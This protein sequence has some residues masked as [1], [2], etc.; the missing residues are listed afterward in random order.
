MSDEI[1]WK[2]CLRAWVAI[3]TAGLLFAAARIAVGQEIVIEGDTA[4]IKVKR[5]IEVEEERLLVKAAPFTLKA[6]EGG[7][8]Y[9]WRFPAGFDAVE[10]ASTLQVKAAPKGDATVTVQWVV[11]DFDKKVVSEKAKQVTFIVGEPGPPPVP[12]KPDP[13]K[14]DPPIPLAG[15]RVLIIHETNVGP[16][17]LNLIVSGEKVRNYMKEKG[18]KGGFMALDKDL[19]PDQLVAAGLEKWVPEAFKR[20]DGKQHPWI[21]ISNG[22]TGFEGPLPITNAPTDALNLIKKYGD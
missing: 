15:L 10:L 6:P 8:L 11:I 13:P 20:W 14:P 17:A 7:L 1:L 3:W 19:T 12:P 21:I 4:K 2:R 9:R 18:A 16:T 22:T 5:L